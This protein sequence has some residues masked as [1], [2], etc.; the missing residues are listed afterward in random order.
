MGRPR[1]S[2]SP[3]ATA[4]R[5]LGR[6]GRVWRAHGEK[7]TVRRGVDLLQRSLVASYV[8]ARRGP[9]G[10]GKGKRRSGERSAARGSV[11]SGRP[12]EW[13]LAPTGAVRLRSLALQS[14]TAALWRAVARR[15]LPQATAQIGPLRGEVTASTKGA[16]AIFRGQIHGRLRASLVP[17]GARPRETS[18]HSLCTASTQMGLPW[19][20]G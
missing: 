6:S 13:V 20:K 3:I 19:S 7:S 10:S 11:K 4:L 14:R 18:R 1:M 9:N 5:Y 2:Q 8:G 16:T 12:E 17:A 15:F